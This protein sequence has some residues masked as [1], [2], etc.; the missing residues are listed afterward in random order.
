MIFYVEVT[1]VSCRIWDW[2]YNGSKLSR[3]FELPQQENPVNTLHVTYRNT[4]QLF[5]P[6]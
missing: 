6:Y 2:D 1:V 3:E 4:E 5:W